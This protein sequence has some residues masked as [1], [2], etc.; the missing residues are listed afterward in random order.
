MVLFSF[1]QRIRLFSTNKYV[2]FFLLLFQSFLSFFSFHLFLHSPLHLCRQFYNENSIS[3][4][5]ILMLVM[6]HVLDVGPFQMNHAAADGRQM[7]RG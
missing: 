3:M 7:N 6:V 2:F 5:H 4:V 1:F